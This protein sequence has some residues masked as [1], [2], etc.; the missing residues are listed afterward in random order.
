MV[1]VLAVACGILAATAVAMYV[2]FRVRGGKI[3]ELKRECSRLAEDA[4]SAREWGSKLAKEVE[5]ERKRNLEVA[6]GLGR[7]GSMPVDGVL[8]GLRDRKADR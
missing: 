4:A 7:I 1:N 2:A 5:I 8:D 6:E 3:S